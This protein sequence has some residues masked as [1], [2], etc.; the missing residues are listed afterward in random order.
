MGAL[1]TFLDGLPILSV[2]TFLPIVGALII[3]SIRGEEA[4]VAQQ[5]RQVA[6]W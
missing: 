2:I 6:L 1:V 5:S 4:V 3:L